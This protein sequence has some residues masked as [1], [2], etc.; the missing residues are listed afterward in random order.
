M[1]WQ[2][3]STSTI[4][5]DPLFCAN[6][7]MWFFYSFIRF[8]LFAHSQ[9]TDILLLLFF[10]QFVLFFNIGEKS[11]F[12]ASKETQ[13]GNEKG[14]IVVGSLWNANDLLNCNYVC[15]VV[16][17]HE[18]WPLPCSFMLSLF[19]SSAASISITTSL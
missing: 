19:F 13:L 17:V 11:L 8:H 10:R 18:F 15:F 1:S 16:I 3:F 4:S 14:C 7:D 12:S 9:K 5:K 2:K 6:N